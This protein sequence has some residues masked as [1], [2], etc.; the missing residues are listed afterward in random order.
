MEAEDITK[1]PLAR[2]EAGRPLPLKEGVNPAWAGAI[3]NLVTQALDPLL[4]PGRASLSESEWLEFQNKLAPYQAWM[5]AKPVVVSVI[6][7]ATSP[8]QVRANAAAATWVLTP[9][10]AAEVDALAP[11]A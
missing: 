9:D 2:V 11:P 8:A 7:G 4:Q 10:E 1:L 6:A 5:A 3:A